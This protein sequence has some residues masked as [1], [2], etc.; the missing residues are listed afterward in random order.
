[1]AEYRLDAQQWNGTPGEVIDSS[2]NGFAGRARNTSPVTGLLCNAADLSDG[3]TADYLDLDHR[4][5]DGLRDFTLMLWYRSTN[6]DRSLLL[7]AANAREE[8]ELYWMTRRGDRFEPQLFDDSD[9]R[10]DIDDIDDGAW[11]HLAWTRIGSRN[12]FYVDGQQQ[13]CNQLPQGALD[14]TPT[15]FIVGQEQDD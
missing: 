5:L 14:V 4:A 2:G 12:C 10:I 8:K 15:G 7:S 1:M 9:G 6:R 11:H 3:G 13:D